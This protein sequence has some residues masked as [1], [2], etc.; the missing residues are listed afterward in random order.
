MYT[1]F[2]TVLMGLG[3]ILV[4]NSFWLYMQVI[5]CIFPNFNI[6]FQYKLFGVVFFS[7]LA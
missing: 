4:R 5:I 1:L 3:E 6:E 7:Y 2:T